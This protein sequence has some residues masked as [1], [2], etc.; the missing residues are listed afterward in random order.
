[1]NKLNYD[2][3]RHEIHKILTD[4]LEVEIQ[5][6]KGGEFDFE[7]MEY[8][9]DDILRLIKQQGGNYAEDDE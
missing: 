7:W 6:Y 4:F 8:K 5:A 2:D 1:M 3:V 9:T